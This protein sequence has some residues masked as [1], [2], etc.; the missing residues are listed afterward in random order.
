MFKFTT[1]E[2]FLERY[3][4]FKDEEGEL[5][6]LEVITPSQ[7]AFAESKVVSCH[8]EKLH[9]NVHH[10]DIE[11]YILASI[12]GFSKNYN[13]LSKEAKKGLEK[14]LSIKIPQKGENF[15]RIKYIADKDMIWCMVNIPRIVTHSQYAALSETCKKLREKEITADVTITGF[16]PYT[17]K[18]EPGEEYF[19]DDENQTQL[20]KALLWLEETGHII[21]YDLPFG[22]EILIKE[23]APTLS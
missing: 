21:D 4:M 3:E 15:P 2:D 5:I 13:A 22:K 7:S 23:K 12:Y 16:N 20:E 6:A 1:F 19:K 9:Y 10:D 17:R 11:N 14:I 18:V 8:D